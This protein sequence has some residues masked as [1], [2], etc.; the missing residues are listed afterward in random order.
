MT[1][2]SIQCCHIFFIC[3]SIPGVV[4]VPNKKTATLSEVIEHLE[5]TYCGHLSVELSHI[6][7]SLSGWN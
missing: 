6:S 5:Q 3:E 2:F 7:V 1:L 4:N